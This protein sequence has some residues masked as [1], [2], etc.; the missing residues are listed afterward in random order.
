[1]V[2]I[3]DIYKGGIKTAYLLPIF[4]PATE[5]AGHFI[6]TV[7]GL[8]LINA[9][10]PGKFNIKEILSIQH[11]FIVGIISNKLDPT[12]EIKLICYEMCTAQAG[13]LAN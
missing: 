8:L 3:W 4:L 1:M 6:L 12:S 7:K 2:Y 13:V 5:L 11:H 9:T 10:V